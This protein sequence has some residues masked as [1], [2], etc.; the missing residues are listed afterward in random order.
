MGSRCAAGSWCGQALLPGARED[1]QSAQVALQRGF[2]TRPGGLAQS[3]VLLR[4]ISVR[5]GPRFLGAGRDRLL[6]VLHPLRL[7]TAT[8][9]VLS[10][11]YFAAEA[12]CRGR[13]G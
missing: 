9:I 5:I 8:I 11:S 7:I 2:T 12:R 3:G 13:G 6:C 1:R 4:S 10:C